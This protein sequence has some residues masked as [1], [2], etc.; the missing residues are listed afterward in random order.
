MKYTALL[1]MK[2]NSERVPGKNFR[3]LGGKPLFLWMLDT[4]LDVPSID[5]VVIN[6]DAS[7]QLMEAGL[8]LESIKYDRV[9]IR[10]RKPEL[11]GDLVSMNLIIEDDIA[12]KESDRYL[13]T[14]VTNPFITKATI[15]AAIDQF[16]SSPTSD[17]L[18][19]VNKFQTRFYTAEGK[20]V[21]HDP[22]KLLRTQ[23]LEPW[24]EENSCLYIFTRDSFASTKARIGNH[25]ILFETPK[26][27]SI[28]I[29][30]PSDWDL[31]NAIANNFSDTQL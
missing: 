17:S 22:N 24:F 15:Q 20:P 7:N 16:D 29:D 5:E 14:H 3:V 8:D 1:P 6:T 18:F 11:I 23:D 4:L 12:A 19:S 30:E 13:M 25:P 10:N 9:T 27:E 21:N 2:A 26:I 28:D 31:A